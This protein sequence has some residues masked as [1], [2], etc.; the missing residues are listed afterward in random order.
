MWKSTIWEDHTDDSRLAGR[1]VM[2]FINV[3]YFVLEY[4]LFANK[5]YDYDDYKPSLEISLIINNCLNR[6][7][8]ALDPSVMF[9]QDYSC[10]IEKIELP[11]TRFALEES[12]ADPK[13]ISKN[14]ILT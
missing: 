12:I 7:L 14:G 4:I 10:K 6:R 5:Y 8:V 13:R 3:I 11:K 9:F 2:S 1:K